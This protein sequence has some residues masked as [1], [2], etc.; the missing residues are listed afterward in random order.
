MTPYSRGYA[1]GLKA[2]AGVVATNKI[3]DELAYGSV[4]QAWLERAILSLTI[5][6]EAD[7]RGAAAEGFSPSGS[8]KHTAQSVP[9]PNPGEQVPDSA[10]IAQPTEKEIATYRDTFRREL[11]KRMDTK[12]PSASPSTEAHEIALRQFVEN[13]NAAARPGPSQECVMVPRAVL[14]WLDGRGPHP[15]TG[16]WFE[17]PEG[18]P[19][20]WWRRV[21]HEDLRLLS[22]ATA[23]EEHSQHLRN[24]GL[25][26]SAASVDAVDREEHDAHR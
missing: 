2:A 16:K 15:R 3:G 9:H 6:G 10:R 17:R 11:D 1:A 12:H 7:Q 18:A 20:Y 25:R 19:P 26:I 5:Q 21:L 23:K 24:E 13:R 8:Q 14:D 4:T 22:L